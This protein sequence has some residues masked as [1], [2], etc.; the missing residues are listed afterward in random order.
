MRLNNNAAGLKTRTYLIQRLGLER[1]YFGAS[2]SDC[3]DAMSGVA[4]IDRPW[5]G[6]CHYNDTRNDSEAE[7]ERLRERLRE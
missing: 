1:Y 3:P 7:N 4:S 2:L 6:I 5:C